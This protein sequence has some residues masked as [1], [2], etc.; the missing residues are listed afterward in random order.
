MSNAPQKFDQFRRSSSDDLTARQLKFG[1][2]W[3]RRKAGFRRLLIGV[4]LLIG[5][6]GIGLGLYTIGDYLIAGRQQEKAESNHLLTAKIPAIRYHESLAPLDPE[7]EAVSVL[8]A[9]ADLY[10]FVVKAKN[11][12]EDWYL[13]LT[14]TFQ[15]DERETEPQTVMLVP[16]VDTI[17]SSLGYRTKDRPGSANIAVKR[18]TWNRISAHSAPN[19][20]AY[21]QEHAAL[22]IR[23]IQF[24]EGTKTPEEANTVQANRAFFSIQNNTA[25]HFKEIPVYVLFY[26]NGSLRTV[27]RTEVKEFRSSET[28]QIEVRSLKTDI[29]ITSL[30]VYPY[31]PVFDESV[32]MRQ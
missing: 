27:E 25:F 15:F 2:W 16:G 13:L 31:V 32:Y 20:L 21:I 29:A 17:V 5:V 26:Q 22:S 14:Y 8:P 24:V 10:D 11:P 28:R 30:E 3:T 9:T 23:D 12:N 19:P 1:E 6:G 4:L 18:V 7:F